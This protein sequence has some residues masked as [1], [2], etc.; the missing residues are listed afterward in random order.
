MTRTEEKLH[1]H[2]GSDAAQ[3]VIDAHPFSCAELGRR[4]RW[5]RSIQQAMQCWELQGRG[6]EYVVEVLCDGNRVDPRKS[7][8]PLA[9]E[10][11]F[12]EE[13]SLIRSSMSPAG[14]FPDSVN[15]SIP[16]LYRPLW[17]S[18][19]PMPWGHDADTSQHRAAMG[20]SAGQS[21]SN[22]LSDRYSCTC[23]YW[24]PLSYGG[25]LLTQD[26]I[27]HMLYC[28][29]A[30]GA[31]SLALWSKL[32]LGRYA[33]SPAVLSVL[34]PW[35][36]RMETSDPKAFQAVDSL[37]RSMFVRKVLAHRPS[38][39]VSMV[40]DLITCGSRLRKK[41]LYLEDSVHGESALPQVIP[42][43]TY[44]IDFGALWVMRAVD[45]LGASHFLSLD[46]QPHEAIEAG[47]YYF[48]DNSLGMQIFKGESE[49]ASSSGEEYFGSSIGSEHRPA[50]APGHEYWP[51]LAGF[52]D[53][54][55][56]R[57][58]NVAHM[59]AKRQNRA[60]L[61]YEWEDKPVGKDGYRESILSPD[62]FS[63]WIRQSDSGLGALD[64][65]RLARN[66]W[67]R[68]ED[69]LGFQDRHECCVMW[70]AI[71]N[72]RLDQTHKVQFI[73]DRPT[74]DLRLQL[75]ASMREEKQFMV[76]SQCADM[77]GIKVLIY[78]WEKD[79][80]YETPEKGVLR[81]LLQAT[82]WLRRSGFYLKG[83]A[84]YESCE[85]VAASEDME[86]A[87]EMLYVSTV[88]LLGESL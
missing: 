85:S 32:N 79:Q 50:D 65:L 86:H 35:V 82:M 55:N 47:L 33:V 71:S 9:I 64:S 76:E 54:L 6:D 20:T 67:I 83:D 61:V 48:Y 36:R 26:H 25:G 59:R 60:W 75:L 74:V 53:R 10:K 81:R 14:D 2:L 52:D 70:R 88:A 40:E 8:G 57:C 7:M 22:A 17:N 84:F 31:W 46:V 28:R 16:N 87:A 78:L 44:E 13:V 69:V 56:T 37:L 39:K 58:T 72:S 29:N 43:R 62:Q 49:F 5:L 80:N 23:W 19:Q 38:P 30:E 77:S 41:M 34:E 4:E 45:L 3:F 18:D 11:S 63:T 66:K 51:L 24:T 21:T 12:V 42:A 1:Y 15:R 73:E 68:P 27:E